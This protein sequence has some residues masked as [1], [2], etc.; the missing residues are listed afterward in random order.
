MIE[1]RERRSLPACGHVVA[2]E[3]GHRVEPE[4][5]G[6]HRAVADLVGEPGG[7]LVANRVAGEAHQR[8]LVSVQA[9]LRK[10]SLG[11]VG[12]EDGERLLGGGAR[13]ASA[14]PL[15]HG[16]QPL[17]ERRW[18]GRGAPRA[19]CR[20]GDTVR[21]DQRRVHPVERGPAH[22]AEG[23]DGMLCVGAAHGRRRIGRS[24]A[25]LSMHRPCVT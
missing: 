13:V 17:A 18:I 4:P 1:G 23:P 5:A 14:A 10:Q 2:A 6:Q 7:R 12:V 19:E 8:D 9:R 3:I 25:A 21:L 15:D 22:H 24:G 11:E 16:P 20:D